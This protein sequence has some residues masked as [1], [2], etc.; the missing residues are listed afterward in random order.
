MNS[1]LLVLAEATGHSASGAS[2]SITELV[3]GFGLD[4]PAILAQGV[5]FIV[6]A[7]ILWYFAFKP[8]LATMDERQKKIADGLRY[9]E[10]MKAKLDATKQET[11]A[12][13]Q[14]AREQ[15]VQIIE[16]ARQ[17]AKV[18]LEKQNQE[19]T[20][21]A[22][23]LLVKAQHAIELEHRK[24]L[25]EAREEVA[26]LVVVTSERVLARQLSDTE[27]TAYNESAAREL[28]IA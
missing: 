12:L 9:T 26:R 4:V 5:S 10:E 11:T 16:E 22:N 17:S 8:V 2:N 27:R 19:A 6:V 23:D 1:T 20:Q 24:M 21:K 3:R 28:N 25:A 7:L 18:F 13:I 14:K 15:S